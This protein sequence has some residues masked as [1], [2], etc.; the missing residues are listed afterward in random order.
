[1]KNSKFEFFNFSLGR[2]LYLAPTNQITINPG[3]LV[4]DIEID[5]DTSIGK[6]FEELSQT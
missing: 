6:I 1:L 4:K 3:R 2:I 5:S